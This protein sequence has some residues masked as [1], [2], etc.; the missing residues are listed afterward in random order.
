PL[1]VQVPTVE[2][3]VTEPA[4]LRPPTATRAPQP[5]L[6][7]HVVEP[8]EA[9]DPDDRA[10]ERVQLRHGID[11]VDGKP[12]RVTPGHRL[13]ER[14]HG[15]DAAHHVRERERGSVDV[16]PSATQGPAA[17]VLRDVGLLVLAPDPL[18]QPVLDVRDRVPAEA[19]DVAPL[20]DRPRHRV[21]DRREDDVREFSEPATRP[22]DHVP[23]RIPDHA[24]DSRRATLDV[25][26]AVREPLPDPAVRRVVLAPL[27]SERV[28]RPGQ[29]PPR[30]FGGVDPSRR[31]EVDEFRTLLPHDRPTAPS[32]ASGGKPRDRRSG[33]ETLVGVDR[34]IHVVERSLQAVV[35]DRVDDPVDRLTPEVRPPTPQPTDPVNP[36]P[37]PALE[38]FH[39][40]RGGARP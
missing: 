20:P 30:L 25:A 5:A 8:I 27:T 23:G 1:G 36:V 34:P 19:T 26:P 3:V 13:I 38:G 4:P 6:P 7:G 18:D 15:P 10:R 40:A 16:G 21:E 29:H 39:P 28:V 9:T 31:G 22:L 33:G 37:P 14:L 35:P 24:T 2:R 17:G 12:A 32:E 11:E